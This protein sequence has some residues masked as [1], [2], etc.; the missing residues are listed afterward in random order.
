MA[1]GEAFVRLIVI[2]I[3]QSRRS[4]LLKEAAVRWPALS[5]IEVAWIDLLD[6]RLDLRSVVQRGDVVR[7]DSP[8]RDFATEVALL[9]LG[10]QNDPGDAEIPTH[11]QLDALR[12]ERGRLLWPAAWYAGFCA[13]LRMLAAQLSQCPPHRLTSDITTICTAFDKSATNRQLAGRGISVPAAIGRVANFDELVDRCRSLRWP[14]AFLK[15]AYGSSGTGAV[16]LRIGADRMQAWTT[17]EVAT[18]GSS[19]LLYNT[20]AVRMLSSIGDIRQVIGCLCRHVVH[21]ERWIPK[22]GVG[23]KAFDL[24]VV[25]IGG[26]PTHIVARLSNSPMTNLHLLNARGD[27]HRVR[28]RCGEASW[29]SMLESCRQSASSFGGC[30]CI[31]IDALFAPTFRHHAVLEVNAFGDLL[32]GILSGGQD[33]YTAELLKA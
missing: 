16:A 18:D 6:G 13:A 29:N 8:G 21:V 24:R 3:A 32:P 10:L 20:R 4:T 15:I 14:Q 7:I 22:A 9:R 11:A 27:I 23:G 30:H 33:T 26:E 12:F 17:T 25:T 5:V 19:A 1:R 2:G 31:G 28:E